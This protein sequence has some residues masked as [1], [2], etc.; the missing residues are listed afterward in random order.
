MPTPQCPWSKRSRAPRRPTLAG[1]APTPDRLTARYVGS[2]THGQSTAQRLRGGLTPVLERLAPAHLPHAPRAG[3]LPPARDVQA[4][5]ST[6]LQSPPARE[7]GRNRTSLT[8]M[9]TTELG[10]LTDCQDPRAPKHLERSKGGAP[11]GIGSR[12]KR[13]A[14]QLAFPAPPREGRAAQQ[15]HRPVTGDG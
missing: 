12:D 11:R 13:T 3:P 10:R 14:T 4:F 1:C 15:L 7:Q 9:R 5:A 2:A 6:R 8:R